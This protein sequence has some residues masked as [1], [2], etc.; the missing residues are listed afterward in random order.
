MT[1]NKTLSFQYDSEIWNDEIAQ[2]QSEAWAFK[3]YRESR[4]TFMEGIA[5]NY[6]EA[7]LTDNL[8]NHIQTFLILRHQLFLFRQVLIQ[9]IIREDLKL[10][11]NLL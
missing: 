10:F 8:K 7:E 3:L 5:R 11:L 1:K 9:L 6:T 2:A 4:K